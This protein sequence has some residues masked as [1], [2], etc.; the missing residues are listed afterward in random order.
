M[1]AVYA[2]AILAYVSRSASAA[3]DQQLRG[4]FQF[5]AAMVEQ[6]PDGGITW[7]GEEGGDEDRPWL[8]VWSPEG[9]LLYRNDQAAKQPLPDRDLINL[10]DDTVVT[11][12]DGRRAAARAEPA[13]ADCLEAGGDPGRALRRSD[14]RS[15]SA[16][17]C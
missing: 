6:T 5:A 4:D 3:L 8:Q 10:P 15:R 17:S 13:R 16:T 14:A 9:Q 1:L 12:P 11:I 7:S 2:A